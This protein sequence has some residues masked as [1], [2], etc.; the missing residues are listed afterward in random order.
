MKTREILLMA[1]LACHVGVT[2]LL[3]QPL[4]T[5]LERKNAAPSANFTSSNLPIIVIDTHGQ[6]ILDE[7]KITADMGVIYNG[8]GVRNYLTDPFNHYDNKIGIE[9]RGASS[10]MFPKKQFGLETRDAQGE[11][12]DVSLLGLPEESDW[13]L[14]ASYSDKTLMRNVLAYKLANDLGHYASRTRYCEVVLNGDYHGVYILMEK[15]KRDKNRVNITKMNTTDVAGEAV[16]GGYIFKIDKLAG[17]STQGWYSAHKPYAGAWQQIYYQYDYPDQDE[18]VPAQKTYLQ[19]YVRAFEDLMARPDYADPQNGY[20][21]VLDVASFVDYFIIEEVARNVD[22]YRLSAFMHKD[23]DSKNPKLK[24]GPLWDFDLAF[25]NADYYEGAKIAGW[26]V[27]FQVQ[28][29]AFPLP[30]W[31]QKL[32]QDSN[33]VNALKARWEELRKEVITVPRLYAYI[34]SVA[35]YIDEAQARNFQRWPILGTYVW[36]NAYIGQTYS[37]ELSYFKNWLQMRIA[38]MDA[39]MP[40]RGGTGAAKHA[41]AFPH[42]FT[43]AQNFPN[44]IYAKDGGSF[45][46][47]STTIAFHLERSAFVSL[48]IFNLSGH[49]IAALVEGELPAGDHERSFSFN[50]L[51]SGVYFY[52][53]QVGG[54]VASKK[55]LILGR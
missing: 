15:I 42:A 18:I 53:L 17:S 20:A 44:P 50:T 48:K 16:T 19:N 23:R 5:Q 32:M 46:N 36:P 34:D 11:D 13:I 9:I 3:A 35:N 1:T 47:P 51:A 28:S 52:R 29:D 7:P 27:D 22:G 26:Q 24:M 10:Q 12:L 49:E 54:G 38:W 21:Q 25:G 6:Q 4:D 33:F 2:Y 43:L 8:P 55:L 39:R 30:F 37:D 45:D 41:Q 40:E 31:W 14:S